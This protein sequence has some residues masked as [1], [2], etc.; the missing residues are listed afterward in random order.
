MQPNPV[1]QYKVTLERGSLARF[2]LLIFPSRIF[3]IPHMSLQVNVKL[4]QHGGGDTERIMWFFFIRKGHAV[5]SH[6]SEKV[7]TLRSLERK[8]VICF[9]NGLISEKDTLTEITPVTSLLHSVSPICCLPPPRL[10]NQLLS[11]SE[12]CL[13]DKLRPRTCRE[14]Q[15]F[16]SCQSS[17]WTVKGSGGQFAG[18]C[19]VCRVKVLLV[20][21]V[22]RCLPSH[23]NTEHGWRGSARVRMCACLCVYTYV[24]ACA[25]LWL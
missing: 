25:H 22:L 19:E 20:S 2:S 15:T 6:A 4:L 3:D 8:K 13:S 14:A 12:S 21:T 11:A 18:L 5:F 10:T 1:V 16:Q 24:E 9:T 17:W 7:K 23:A